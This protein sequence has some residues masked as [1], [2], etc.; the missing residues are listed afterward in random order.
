MLTDCILCKIELHEIMKD[1]PQAKVVKALSAAAKV[2]STAPDPR[3]KIEAAMWQ[4][5][6]DLPETELIEIRD[7][8]VNTLQAELPLAQVA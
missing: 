7:R 8:A 2:Q 6:F 5:F 4:M 1:T 3:A